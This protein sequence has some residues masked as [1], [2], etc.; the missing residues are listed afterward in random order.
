[1]DKPVVIDEYTPDWALQFIEEQRLLKSIIGD[2]AI[3]VEHIGWVG[4][5]F[6]NL[7]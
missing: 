2:K 1:M 7:L 6:K 4:N 3:A 5:I